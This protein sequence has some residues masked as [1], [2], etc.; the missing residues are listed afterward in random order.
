[1]RALRRG[2]SNQDATIGRA[3]FQTFGPVVE[4]RPDASSGQPTNAAKT[5]SNALARQVTSWPRS[6]IT[7]EST[8]PTRSSK[9]STDAQP[10]SWITESQY[11]SWSADGGLVMPKQIMTGM[12]C[13]MRKARWLILNRSWCVIA[14]PT[15][16]ETLIQIKTRRDVASSVTQRLLRYISVLRSII[17]RH[18]EVR[19]EVSARV[20]KHSRLS[21]SRLSKKRLAL[22]TVPIGT[23]L[24]A[25]RELSLD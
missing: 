16:I 9:T 18:I 10:Q 8:Q 19:S 7:L 3:H 15:R 11:R 1:M 12:P 25:E 13:M 20:L 21:I 2:R 17:A 5:R 6:T 4:S 22:V 14:Q 24:S 23:R